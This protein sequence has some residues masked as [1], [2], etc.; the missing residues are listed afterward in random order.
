LLMV[1]YFLTG[2]FLYIFSNFWSFK[3][4]N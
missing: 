1:F 3:I 4:G 2:H